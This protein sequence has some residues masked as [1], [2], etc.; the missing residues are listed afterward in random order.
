MLRLQH[1]PYIIRG[2]LS[3][4]IVYHINSTTMYDTVRF[5]H[6]DYRIDFNALIQN[7]TKCETKMKRERFFTMKDI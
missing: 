1:V 4:K 7:L 2:E 6:R 5:Y 3:T